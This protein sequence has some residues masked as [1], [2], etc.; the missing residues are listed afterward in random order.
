M[1]VNRKEDA[2]LL[3]A[4]LFFVLF[5]VIL[6]LVLREVAIFRNLFLFVF[7]VFVIIHV[8]GDDVQVDGMDLR[9]L[10]F[11][12]ALWATENLAFFHFVLIDVDLSGTF[13]AA[14]HGFHPP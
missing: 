4:E 11:G 14:D 2:R 10:Q 7:L 9:D 12:L 3:R 6:F 8:F 5:L 1:A 13:W